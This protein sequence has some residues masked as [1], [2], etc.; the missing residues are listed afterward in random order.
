MLSAAC[1]ALRS[2]KTYMSKEILKM[3]CYAYFHSAMSYEI[4]FWGNFTDSTHI[5]KIQKGALRIITGSRNRDS[6]SNL[7]KHLK[8]LL[9]HTQSYSH[10]YY[11][12]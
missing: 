8:I 7:F 12:W 2:V 6:C 11:L 9:F 3:V 4:I 1:Y 5:F 10:S